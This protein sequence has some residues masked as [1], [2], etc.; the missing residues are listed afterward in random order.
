L[1]SS[2]FVDLVALMIHL[3][4]IALPGAVA[5]QPLLNAALAAP[6]EALQA[7]VPIMDNLNAG[8]WTRFID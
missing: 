5:W 3:R 1:V 4:A 7:V 8:T 2:P 6:E